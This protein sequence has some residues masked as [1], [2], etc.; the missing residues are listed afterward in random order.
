MDEK[1]V[2]SSNITDQEM[3]IG[4]CSSEGEDEG[5]GDDEEEEEEEMD[6]EM[7]SEDDESEADIVEEEDVTNRL[8]VD[9]SAFNGNNHSSQPST[10]TS[11]YSPSS[12]NYL[13]SSR[14]DISENVV[15]NV[16]FIDFRGANFP[17]CEDS[18]NQKPSENDN[19]HILTEIP[20]VI[21][22]AVVETPVKKLAVKLK[23][24]KG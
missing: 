3:D 12:S 15:C 17:L 4:D 5:E 16:V 21:P 24:C 14:R 23:R 10:S 13:I 8:S 1:G 20:D 22:P 7:E 11:T 9:M 2:L 19:K 6:E 18:S